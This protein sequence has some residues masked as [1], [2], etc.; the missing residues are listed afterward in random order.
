M[1][2]DVHVHVAPPE[3]LAALGKVAEVVPLPGVEGGVRASL[4]NQ[5]VPMPPPF[6]R[7]EALLARLDQAGIDVAVISLV[8]LL[9][10]YWLA[11]EEARAIA[12]EANRGIARF[13][14]ASPERFRW[15]AHV[16]MQDVAAAIDVL[17]EAMAAGAQGALIGTNVAGRN[18]DDPALHRFFAAAADLGAFVLVHAN[19]CLA[20]ERF[21]RHYL[22]NLVGNPVEAG[23]AVASVIMGRVLEQSKPLN[24]CFCHGGGAAAGMAARWD[25]GWKTGRSGGTALPRAPS[26]YFRSLYFDSLCYGPEQLKLLVSLAGAD[27]I[28]IGTDTPFPIAEADPAGFIRGIPWLGEA[29]KA[30]ILG[31]TARALFR[32]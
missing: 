11:P 8:P 23:L 12:V 7:P 5:V 16:P 24:L 32:L 10:G 6:L 26:S 22:H 2:V 20:P 4:H 13:A 14:A 21:A 18:L 19:D 1:I 17:T 30:A 27:R 15:L 29:D 25:Q 28:M 3:F 31:G 9:L